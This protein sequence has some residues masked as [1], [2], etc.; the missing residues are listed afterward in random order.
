VGFVAEFEPC[1]DLAGAFLVGAV[2]AEDTVHF[3]HVGAERGC[4]IGFEGVVLRDE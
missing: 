4:G 1:E 2:V 3:A